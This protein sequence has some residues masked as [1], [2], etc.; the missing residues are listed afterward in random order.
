MSPREKSGLQVLTFQ[1]ALAKAGTK[2][3]HV[4]LGNG[5]SRA[6]RDDIFRYGS[7]FSQARFDFLSEEARKAFSA[8]GTEDFEIVMGAMRQ[9]SKL[10]SVYAPNQPALAAS[11]SGD[12]D[13]LREVLV[14]TI[15]S[16]HPSRPSDI[17]PERYQACREFLSHF[18][19]IYTVNYDLLLYWALMQDELEPKV[20]SDDG[21]RQPDAGPE[22]Y[23]TWQ[24]DN[25]AKQRIF[26]LHGALHVFDAGHQIQKFTWS[27]TGVALIDQIRG[28]LESGRYPLFVAESSSDSKLA[29]IQHSGFLNRAYRSLASIGGSLFIYGHSMA[30]SDE[31][32]L[33]LL[34][35]GKFDL[36][37][38]SLF[39]DSTNPENTLI[40][41]RA[42]EI[43]GRRTPHHPLAVHFFDA[44]SAN[45]WGPTG[46]TD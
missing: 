20:D 25:T 46:G 29:R 6:C 11:L 18:Q 34:D 17:E 37:F 41:G 21:F 27:N 39:G 12:A 31:H 33:R 13:G 4:L 22:P 42:S 23:V 9:A 2:K 32:L 10:A 1:Q 7:L 5:F 15:A 26:F 16:S 43:K 40:V 45:V 19:S 44:A 38:V 28:A 14:Q 8:L 24:V 3:P 36:L 30:A 35:R